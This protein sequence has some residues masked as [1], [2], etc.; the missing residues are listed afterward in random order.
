MVSMDYEKMEFEK[1]LLD[2]LDGMTKK[3]ADRLPFGVVGMSRE[4]LIELYNQTESKL[5][6]LPAESVMGQPFFSN[7]G[8]CMNNWM[9]AQRF[10]DEVTIDAVID[11][12]LTLRMRPTP[13]RLRLLKAPAISRRYILIE[14]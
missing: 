2:E 5:A 9:V 14:R 6:G 10:E 12:V 7:V 11:Y 13:V 4:G 1:I 8:Q 3:Q